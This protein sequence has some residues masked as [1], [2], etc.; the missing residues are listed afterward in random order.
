MRS[1]STFAARAA[2]IAAVPASAAAA[3]ALSS[4]HL[5]AD[6]GSALGVCITASAL[7]AIAAGLGPI[8]L[9]GASRMRAV[10]TVLATAATLV[11]GG[12]AWLIVVILHL[13]TSSNAPGL[14]ALGAAAVV[15]I[16]G[17]AV[18]LRSTSRA[19]WA[20]PLVIVLAL[21]VSLGVLA[22]LTGGPHYCET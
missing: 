15:Y 19:A 21:G 5:L 11:I 10:A 20:W 9:R 4:V 1:T 7:V 18:A 3:A 6:Y 14:A 16:P 22:L 8:A 13:C 12:T 2:L 17:S